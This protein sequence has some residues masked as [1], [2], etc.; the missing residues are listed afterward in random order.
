MVS[1]VLISVTPRGIVSVVR[2]VSADGVGYKGA[3]KAF[4]EFLKM[5]IINLKWNNLFQKDNI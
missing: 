3:I 1:I 4:E 5:H 2:L